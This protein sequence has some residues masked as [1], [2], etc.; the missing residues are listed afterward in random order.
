MEDKKNLIKAILDTQT[1]ETQISA[2]EKS[3][4]IKLEIEFSS[5]G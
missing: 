1:L 5:G 2:Y 3:K 4:K